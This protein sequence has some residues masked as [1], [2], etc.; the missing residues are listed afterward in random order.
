ME[1]SDNSYWDSLPPELQ[2]Q[3]QCF[4]CR[5]YRREMSKNLSE[6]FKRTMNELL[7]STEWVKRALE[8]SN[9][10]TAG[11]VSGCEMTG[12]LRT[13]AK[14]GVRRHLWDGYWSRSWEIR[15]DGGYQLLAWSC[16]WSARRSSDDRWKF[17]ELAKKYPTQNAVTWHDKKR[18]KCKNM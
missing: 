11:I 3:I 17:Y 2:Q 12:V 15:Y 6:E 5:S 16:D 4:A 14:L 7:C 8:Y 1:S 9:W 10:E 13:K 18:A